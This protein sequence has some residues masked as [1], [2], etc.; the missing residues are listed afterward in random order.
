MLL[1]SPPAD[2][3]RDI[4]GKVTRT[5][6][7]KSDWGACEHSQDQAPVRNDSDASDSRRAQNQDLIA[8]RSDEVDRLHPQADPE[9]GADTPTVVSRP[10]YS[11]RRQGDD[12]GGSD[13][14]AGDGCGGE[15]P[16]APANRDGRDS[17]RV[18]H[19]HLCGLGGRDPLVKELALEDDEAG[20]S[21]G[22]DGSTQNHH[23]DELSHEPE[24]SRRQDDDSDQH[25]ADNQLKSERTPED[26][27][28]RAQ[29]DAG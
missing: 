11:S 28:A 18:V 4:A 20:T 16:Q 23:G 15:S 24:G 9:H 29:R 25:D 14:S 3:V 8:Y 2:L 6:V 17:P 13:D 12:E 1:G 5:S 22:D 26:L 21:K 19:H 27:R 7:V 10:D